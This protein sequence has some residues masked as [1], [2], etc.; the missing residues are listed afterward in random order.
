MLMARINME[1]FEVFLR[2]ISSLFEESIS[3][4]D[5]RSAVDSIQGLNI[6]EFTSRTFKL[7]YNCESVGITID[8]VI[9]QSKIAAVYFLTDEKVAYL[10]QE[11]I[12]MFH[13]PFVRKAAITEPLSILNPS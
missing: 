7:N 1:E 10:I 3:E 11:V 13:L 6:N 4:Q 2:I 5:I 8:I 9:E 12:A